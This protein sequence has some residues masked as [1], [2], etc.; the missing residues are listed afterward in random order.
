MSAFGDD[1]DDGL[2]S[3]FA[4]LGF[5]DAEF[6]SQPIENFETTLVDAANDEA[7]SSECKSSEL[8]EVYSR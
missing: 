5:N 7:E 8:E 3:A 2:C 4:T 1:D 6:E